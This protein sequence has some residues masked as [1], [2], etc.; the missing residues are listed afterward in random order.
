MNLGLELLI[1]YFKSILSRIPLRSIIKIKITLFNLVTQNALFVLKMKKT[2]SIFH[3]DIK[4]LALIVQKRWLIVRFV[5]KILMILLE[6][7]KPDSFI[8]NYILYY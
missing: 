7:I 6:Y 4:S 2:A 1:T 8:L 3:V 5:N